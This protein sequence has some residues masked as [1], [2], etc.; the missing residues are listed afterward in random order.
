LISTTEL[1]IFQQATISFPP[2]F[3]NL[4]SDLFNWGM[5]LQET[6]GKKVFRLT[7]HSNRAGPACEFIA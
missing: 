3:H 7:A 2:V 1:S 6:S 5:V 4:F